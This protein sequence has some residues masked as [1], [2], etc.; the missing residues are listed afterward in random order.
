MLRIAHL[1]DDRTAGDL[2]RYLAFLSRDAA[3]GATAEHRAVS[4]SRFAAGATALEAEVI[5]SHLPMRLQCLPGLM[6]LRARHPRAT[7]IHVEHHHCEGSAAATRNR[8]RQR[9]MLRTGYALFNHVVALSA[10][11]AHWMRRH[12]LVATGQLTVI[13]ACADLAPFAALPDPQGPVRHIGA[14]GRLHRQS[15]FDMLIE[16]FG[17]VSDPEARLDI[18]GDGPQRAELRALARHDLRIRVHGNTTRLAALRSAEAIAIP[19][20][21]QASALA[22][23]EAQAA[24]RRVLHSGRDS[25]SELQGPGLVTVADLSVAAW[26]RALS[27]VLAESAAVPRISVTGAYEPTVQG[28]QA[29]LGRLTSRKTAGR[30]TLAAI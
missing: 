8:G 24:G 9:A 23:Q 17:V 2:A 18:F 22:A 28:W 5:V 29:L 30:S 11:Q 27:D 1:H 21:W 16:A 14:I 13:P 26:S 6:A 19:A 20:R 12:A 7:L 10:S 25:L 15:G 4:V 3:L